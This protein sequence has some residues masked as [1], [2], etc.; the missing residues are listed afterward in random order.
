MLAAGLP[1]VLDADALVLLA[2]S[3]IASPRIFTPHDG[4]LLALERAFALDGSG[5]K[6]ERALALAKASGA[7]VVAKGADTLVAAPDG[8]LTCAP[9]GSSWL[10]TAGTGDVLA[11]AIA[12]QIATGAE[13]FTAACTGVWLH[14]EAARSLQGPFTAG[15]LAVALAGAYA[16]AL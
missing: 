16:A 8:R 2:G 9:R 5:S 4:E 14:G 1:L 15:A 7:V 3:R 13:A 6:P 10:S 12:S 11:G